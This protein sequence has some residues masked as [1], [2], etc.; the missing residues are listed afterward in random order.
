MGTEI[1]LR[2][3]LDPARAR[4][5]GRDPR[6][7][8]SPLRHRLSSVYFDT[9]DRALARERVGLRLRRVAG[10]WL[11]TLKSD[12][13]TGAGYRRGEW[14]SP[15][16]R[17][18]IDF[19]LLARTPMADWFARPDHREALAPVFETRVTRDV[20]IVAH[21][22]ATVEVALDRGRIIAGERSE[23]LLELELELRDGPVDALFD[24]ALALNRDHAL[25]LEPRSKAARGFA[26]LEGRA[27]APA[28]A[29]RPALDPAASTEEAFVAIA[30]SCLAQ[31]LANAHGVG[32]GDDPEYVHQARVALRR[33]RAA[34]ASF[35]RTIPREA[36]VQ[37]ASGAKLIAGALG[38]ERDL[39]VFLLE[40]LQPLA[41]QGHGGRL[42][43]LGPAL[44]VAR[45]RARRRSA[46]AVSAPAFTRYVLEASRWLEACAWRPDPAAGEP[47]AAL[48]ARQVLPVRR[49]A[50][51]VLGRRHRA[52]RVSPVAPSQRGTED[53]HALRIALK[54]LRYAADAFAPVFAR[55]GEGADY[56]DALAGLQEALGDLN[57]IATGRLLV[58]RL[59]SAGADPAAIEPAL[60]LVE[61]WLAGREVGDLR[62]AD[63]AW[64][65]FASAKRFW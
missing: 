39:D 25:A 14:E 65:R 60:A 15:V 53:R 57:D 41:A 17:R 23:A 48:A 10:A 38:E 45:A 3:T 4:A 37:V 22:G 49:H 50:A 63:R 61:G 28:R 29:R 13:A 31:L 19:T 55:R 52:L 1:E 34:L 9:P 43:V 30:W 16:A 21:S 56:L 62:A 59:R 54:K 26:L 2:F 42:A 24:F 40:T 7:T 32:I 35:R 47:A 58:E 5:I 18:A 11:Q 46:E 51:R 64:A 44:D 12:A 6:L 33:L 20:W 8:G 27:P 36:A